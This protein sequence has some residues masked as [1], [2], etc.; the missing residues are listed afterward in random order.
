[1][2][3]LAKPQILPLTS[4][5]FFAALWVIIFSFWDHLGLSE[6]PGVVLAGHLGVDLF[7]ILSG[8]IL[9]HV[10]LE[11]YGTKRFNYKTFLTSRV[12]R[13]FPLHFVTLWLTIFLG[14]GA[15]VA[16]YRV[17]SH[18]L[19]WASLPANLFMVHAWGLAPNAAFNHPSWSISA[20]WFAY[21][22]FPV[23]ASIAWSLRMRPILAF[24]SGICGLFVFYGVFVLSTGKDLS[25]MTIHWGA[26]RIVPSFFYGAMLFIVYRAGAVDN[27]IL[28]LLGFGVSLVSI[29]ITAQ[30]QLPSAL[31]IAAMG[32]LILSMAGID[33]EGKGILSSRPLVY[34]GEI[35]FAAYM[36]YVP[37]KWVYLKGLNKLFGISEDQ[38][39][40]WAFLLGLVLIQI[41]AAILHHLVEIPMRKQVRKFGD[42]VN[43]RSI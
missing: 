11:D 15:L 43:F 8:F 26:L 12:A 31:I 19:D 38:L 6:K 13:I 3:L 10:Y 9:C 34:L 37:F 24:L 23:F 4:M 32:F 22:S 21:L 36:I 33:K 30:Y 16:G 14:I 2:T 17:D 5:R 25:H 18:A 42:R 40:L 20:E 7:F 35:S 27:K 41:C 28:A 1:M 29:V 39:P